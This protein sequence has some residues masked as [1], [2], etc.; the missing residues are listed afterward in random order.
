MSA[1]KKN[2]VSSVLLIA[3]AMSK[4]LIGLVSTLILARVLVPED[5]G[6]VAIATLL[7]GFLE[8][9]AQ[10]GSQQYIL[11]ADKV[12]RDILDTSWTIDLIIRSALALILLLGSPIVV[13]YY[14]DDRL[15]MILVVFSSMM[16]F[17][18]FRNPALNLLRREQEYGK[19][20]KLSVLAKFISVAVA[21]SIALIYESYWAL[22]LGQYTTVVI[23]TLGS[24]V[25]YHYWPK[26]CLKH[27]KE[28]WQFSGWVIPQSI[29]GYLRT[30]FDTMLVSATFGK[31]ELGSYHIMKY[32]AFIPCSQILL[33]ATQPL[34]V[35][36][37]KIK[38][39]PRHFAKQY[40]VTFFITL[41]IAMPMTFTMF[42]YS[43][44]VIR[45]FMGDNWLEYAS[46][47]GVFAL[48]IPAYAMFHH[49]NRALYVFAKTKTMAIYEVISMVILYGSLLAVGLDDLMLFSWLRVS[50]ENALSFVYLLYVS[51][52][53][54][55]AGNTLRMLILSIPCILACTVALL[56]SQLVTVFTHPLLSLM[57]HCF[58]F[59]VVMFVIMGMFHI[60]FRHQSEEWKYI[61]SLVQKAVRPLVNKLGMAR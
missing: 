47:F 37:S 21:V 9:L 10:T 14:G 29:L 20:V 61:D 40:N 50:M 32:L 49:A 12:D 56:V 18:S 34:L 13:D 2:L 4:K 27:A 28:Q 31:S 46:L 59:A 36:L 33:P 58:V 52:R 42:G 7:L 19:I 53:Y 43:E 5:F 24:Y 3:E 11:R 51:I 54:T 23:N 38:D 35:E 15:Q 45:V 17:G 1:V 8:V 6:L 22:I 30:Q 39:T 48:M 57:L 26:W 60:V 44:L 25:I 55:S 16:F 41:L